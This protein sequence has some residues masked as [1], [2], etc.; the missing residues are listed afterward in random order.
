MLG[1]FFCPIVFDGFVNIAY[2]SLNIDGSLI[3]WV[4]YDPDSFD[5]PPI[6]DKGGSNENLE[7]KLMFDPLSYFK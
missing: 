1:Q 7:N 3:V 2:G 6:K 4:D 5:W